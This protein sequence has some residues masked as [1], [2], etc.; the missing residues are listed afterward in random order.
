[1][2]AFFT[3]NATELQPMKSIK[4]PRS[5]RKI[6]P[7]AYA[8]IDDLKTYR[9]LPTRSVNHLD[10]FLFL[11][12]HGPQVYGPEN[13][14]LPFGPHPHRG[15]ETLTFVLKGDIE[16]RDTSGARSVIR[17]GGIQWMTAG[18]GL[19]HSEMSSVE[20]LKHGGEEEVIQLWL[21]LP[22]KQKMIPPKYDGKSKE[23]LTHITDDQGKVLIHLVSGTWGNQQGPIESLTNLTIMSID[24]KTGGNFLARVPEE[25]QIL[26]YV[27]KGN[28]E[29]NGHAAGEH[30]LVEFEHSGERVEIDATEDAVIIFGYGTPFNE[31]IVAQGPFV[32]NSQ[33]E[34]REAFQDYQTGKMGVWEE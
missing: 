11:N 34:I 26:C 28:V 7:A 29:A 5:I 32:M 23:E 25:D 15:F 31:P 13:Q 1:M 27:V 12:H 21:N 2:G 9:A 33:E 16:H 30:D 19:I 8:P 17:E 3:F 22:A 24:L 10:P 18:S 20:F 6:H 4:D 14:G